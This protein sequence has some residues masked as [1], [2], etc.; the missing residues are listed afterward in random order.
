MSHAAVP[1][2]CPGPNDATT[3]NGCT[4]DCKWGPYCG[5]GVVQSP[6]EE[7]DLGTKAN[8]SGYGLDGCTPG[9]K[10]P[11]YC[12]DG[13]VDV[14]EGEQCDLGANNGPAPSCCTATCQANIDC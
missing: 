6:Q 3:Y 8:T 11:H 13:I 5:D 1:A 4:P 14:N 12:G 7:C 2:S 9:C 10:K